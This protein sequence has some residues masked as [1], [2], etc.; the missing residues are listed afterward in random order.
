[1]KRLIIYLFLSIS[2]TFNSEA[3]IKLARKIVYSTPSNPNLLP[4]YTMLD[5]GT[6]AIEVAGLTNTA[7]P[8]SGIWALAASNTEVK[9]DQTFG[10][11][12][13]SEL[14]FKNVYDNL[15]YFSMGVTT[16]GQ[17]KAAGQDPNP[18][19]DLNGMAGSLPWSLANGDYVIIKNVS[20]TLQFF[21]TSDMDATRT[22]LTT[23]QDYSGIGTNVV[24]VKIYTYNNRPYSRIFYPQYKP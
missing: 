18:W 21:K 23:P 9:K 12:N 15:A 6:T 20:G 22:P 8:G 1:M 14:A 11:A 10:L 24:S 5:L 16:G 17:Y 13:G 7:S 4:G 2:V 3:Q 19:Y